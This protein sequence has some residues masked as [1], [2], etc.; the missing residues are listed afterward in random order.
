[1][2]TLEG[3]EAKR[4]AVEASFARGLPGFSIVGLADDEIM[5]SRERVKAA[6]LHY[7]FEFPPLKILINLSPA[8]LT[9]SG[10][11]FDLP[12]ALLVALYHDEI[13]DMGDFYV[14]GELGLDG[15]VKA[16]SEI[17]ALIL[18]LASQEGHL[19]VIVPSEIVQ[20][21]AMVPG[22]EA[23]G[24]ATLNDAI[25]L[26]REHER[27][28]PIEGG[29]L[30][31]LRVEV[32]EIQGYYLSEYPLDFADV[33]GQEVAKRAA[34]IAAA[35]MHNLL[36][37]GSPGCGKSMI[38]KRLRYIL[39]PMTLSDILDKARLQ[40]LEG[41]EP[42]FEPLRPFRSPHHSSTRASIFGG[43]SGRARIGEVAL[44]HRGILF[45][46]ELPH[47]QK[48]VL[49]ALREPLEDRRI[50]I[51]RVNSKVEYQTD[52]LFVAAMNPC[53]C[54]NLLSQ[55]RACRCLPSEIQRYKNRL[56]DPLL[57]RI[58]LY[59]QMN[60]SRLE[61]PAGDDSK[62]LHE[63]V[64][65]AWM[66]QVERGQTSL[67]GRLDET[68]IE[69]FCPLSPEAQTLLAQAV[70]RFALSARA[71]AKVRRVARTIADL[72]GVQE[73]TKEHLMEA[74]SFRRRA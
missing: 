24:V 69:R 72:D 10:S 17:F 18:S 65:A 34:L 62:S 20:R 11:F 49:E 44:A 13:P 60:E 67:N 37:E 35:G 54:G 26:L 46:D 3:V 1:C 31:Y 61:D 58:D 64:I 48:D 66:R 12:I 2:A 50:T 52:F 19:R 22:V 25:A 53:P 38:I 33:R 68:G 51:S 42:T 39:P 47:Y 30:A 9:K 21:V 41:K 40:A 14:F 7:G 36:L 28:A 71:I 15:R 56:S 45:F 4:V 32:G 57:D 27:P 70:T 29:G 74:L 73:I 5:E 23:Y 55:S 43:G 16:T 8:D 63:R 59:V 6:L